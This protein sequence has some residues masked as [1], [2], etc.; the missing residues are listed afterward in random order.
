ML[1]QCPD[2][3]VLEQAERHSRSVPEA[4]IEERELEMATRWLL[5][6]GLRLSTRLAWKRFGDLSAQQEYVL[7]NASQ[8]QINAWA[9]RS[10]FAP[11]VD[12]ILWTEDAQRAVADLALQLACAFTERTDGVKLLG[13]SYFSDSS[14]ADRVRA[15][16]T[17]LQAKIYS[18]LATAA[19]ASG[20]NGRIVER[21]AHMIALQ[22]AEAELRIS[23]ARRIFGTDAAAERTQ[24]GMEPS[25]TA[26]QDQEWRQAVEDGL[27]KLRKEGVEP[28]FTE[29]VVARA[30]AFARDME[31][32][33]LADALVDVLKR[34]ALERN[35]AIIRKDRAAIMDRDLMCG[36]LF[37][38]FTVAEI[39]AMAEGRGGEIEDAPAQIDSDALAASVRSLL[40][41]VKPGSAPW[42]TVA[43][44]LAKEFRKN[45]DGE[46]STC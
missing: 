36:H 4:E 14:W 16:D 28:T 45:P 32:V 40:D 41:G 13:R 5:S 42:R 1:A 2:V 24:F 19:Q 38:S 17:T 29:L 21:K 39:L 22:R 26:Q 7:A 44:E 11:S 18:L 43:S 10:W 6:G 9:D 33:W 31:K 30:V 8:D 12:F 34:G 27:A 35:V 25:G 20:I 15:D 37:R 46:K 3:E 23:E